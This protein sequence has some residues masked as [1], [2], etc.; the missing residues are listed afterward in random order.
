M[1][2]ETT[3][4]EFVMTL[5][6]IMRRA[7]SANPVEG[8]NDKKPEGDDPLKVE[9]N[10][11]EPAGKP[12]ENSGEPAVID[13]PFADIFKPAVASEENT[14]DDPMLRFVRALNLTLPEGK[15]KWEPDTVI[16]LT[17]AQLEASKQKLDLSQYDPEIGILFDF[18]Q[19]NG[20][21]LMGLM[22]DP[23]IKAL[24]ELTLWDAE[25]FFKLDLGRKLGEQGLAEEEIEALVEARI[26]RIDEDEREE[27]FE[28]YQKKVIKEVI[29]PAIAE[30]VN[31][32]NK[33]KAGYREKLK[34]MELAEK[35]RIVES[36]AK[37]AEQLEE[38]V[39]IPISQKN[40]EAIVSKI[41]S[42]DIT[43][44]IEKDPGG[45]QLLGYLV[46]T[47]G[48]NAVNVWKDIVKNQSNSQHYKGVK[49][50]LDI[51][52]NSGQGDGSGSDGGEAPQVNN[53]SMFKS[54]LK[55]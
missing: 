25:S 9:K 44:E 32:L 50:T 27:Y 54:L 51:V 21:S 15:D 26:N 35:T 7:D 40:K 18:V 42:G 8:E 23:E 55:T 34:A 19:N 5:P 37:A 22:V 53:W 52:Y 29:N 36:M 12:A 13:D 28:E 33:E 30:R 14:E 17:Q 47:I 4:D 38:F 11:E 16:E 2:D 46:K 48:P 3:V 20:G 1:K 43:K 49:S 41:R 39:G 10:N 6:L 45:Y 31:A 24:N